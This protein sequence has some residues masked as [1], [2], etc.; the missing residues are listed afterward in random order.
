M[1]VP[2]AQSRGAFQCKNKN[3]ISNQLQCDGRNHCGDGTD[4]SQCSIISG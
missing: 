4:E 3:C 1:I 2:C